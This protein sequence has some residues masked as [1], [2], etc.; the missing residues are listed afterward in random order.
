MFWVNFY[1]MRTSVLFVCLGNICRSP[2]AEGAFINF[3]YQENRAHEFIVDSAGTAGY[4]VGSSPDPR[5]I[6]CARN[7]GIAL[8][9]HA[10]QFSAEDFKKFDY[11]VCMDAKNK[12][13]VLSLDKNNE[14]KNKVFLMGEFIPSLKGGDVPDPYYGTLKDF[15]NVL[16]LV[17]EGAPEL[18]QFIY[19][20]RLD[21]TEPIL[22]KP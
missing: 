11:I 16:D 1:L 18:F 3:L 20:K 8:V 5:I 14:F 2:A 17:Q 7:R 10:R 9:S 13:D 15:E 19:Q 4:H 6:D 12:Q 21:K 22:K